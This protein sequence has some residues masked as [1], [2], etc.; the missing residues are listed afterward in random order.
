M[1]RIHV[2]GYLLLLLLLYVLVT[3]MINH[4]GSGVNPNGNENSANQ[5]AS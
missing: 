4:I 1:R 5:G 3:P 2:L